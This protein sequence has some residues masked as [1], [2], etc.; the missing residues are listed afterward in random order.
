[1]VAKFLGN[2]GEPIKEQAMMYKVV[3]QAVLLHGRSG[4]VHDDDGYGGIWSQ[5]CKTD[6]RNDI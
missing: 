2:T 4:D 6:C 1:M 3:V 5:D